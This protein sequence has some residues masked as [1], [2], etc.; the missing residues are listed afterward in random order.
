MDSTHAVQVNCI[1]LNKDTGSFVQPEIQNN[2]ESRQQFQR[3]TTVQNKS[4]ILSL[5][6]SSLMQYPLVEVTVSEMKLFSLTC[7]IVGTNISKFPEAVATI[8]LKGL[9]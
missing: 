9:G 2:L 1:L 6:L 5:S 3:S 8:V 7:W 4:F